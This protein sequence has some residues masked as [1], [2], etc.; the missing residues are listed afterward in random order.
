[1]SRNLAI[2]LIVSG[3]TIGSVLVYA[4][5]N[6]P[7]KENKDE[8]QA[9]SLIN[10]P[11]PSEGRVNQNQTENMNQVEVKELKIEDIKVGTGAAV[12]AGE[13]V[14]VN[15][16]GTFLDGRKFDSSYD[17]NQ[18]FEFSVGAGNVIQGWDQG[19]VGMQVGGKRKLTIPSDLAYG[20]QGAGNGAIPPN[21]PLVF[22]I[23]L[24]SIK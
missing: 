17:R 19:L 7:I 8:N 13:R 14:E 24:L 16:L 3:L 12:K 4:I 22:E 5:N 6:K 18:P 10:N 23:E 21:T 1:M 11:T 20:S 9:L 15:Y 2:F